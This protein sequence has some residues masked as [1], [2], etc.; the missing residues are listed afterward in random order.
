MRLVE[1]VP[2]RFFWEKPHIT[3]VVTCKIKPYRVYVLWVIISTKSTYVTKFLHVTKL[4]AN[5]EYS[6]RQMLI[7]SY[8]WPEWNSYVRL[9][10]FHTIF[11]TKKSNSFCSQKLNIKLFIIRF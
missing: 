1:E 7:I 10:V 8:F 2:K 5:P 6:T 3:L 11:S 9:G 4:R